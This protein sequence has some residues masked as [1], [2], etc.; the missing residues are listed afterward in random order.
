[1]K[2]FTEQNYYIRT[3][4]THLVNLLEEN[5]YIEL[6]VVDMDI[7]T[8]IIDGEN[9]DISE[10]LNYDL[11]NTG[12]GQ[13]SKDL[14]SEVNYQLNYLLSLRQKSS[15]N[16]FFLTSGTLTYLDDN[17]CEKYAPIV[18]IPIEIDYISRKIVASGNPIANRRLIKLLALKNRD[19]QEEQNRFLETYTNVTF[20]NIATILWIT[21]NNRTKYKK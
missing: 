16:K 10:I 15:T 7:L 1:M 19:T 18:L 5:Y 17:G 21:W 2:R 12:I 8:K 3:I 4:N 14:D 11:L 9:L 6:G 20:N 13:I